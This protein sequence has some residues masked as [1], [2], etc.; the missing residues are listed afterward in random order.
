M[1]NEKNKTVDEYEENSSHKCEEKI[2]KLNQKL[3][4]I[5]DELEE[6]SMFYAKAIK[7]GTDKA[8]K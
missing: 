6:I 2:E 1:I 8:K 3:Q 5:N 7:D 4:E